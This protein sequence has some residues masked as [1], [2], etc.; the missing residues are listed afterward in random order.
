MYLGKPFLVFFPLTLVVLVVK[1]PFA[2]AGDRKRCSFHFWVKK[3]PFRRKCNP[4]VFLPGKSHRQ[5]DLAGYR[6]W[7]SQKVEYD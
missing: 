3:I 4:P 5:R 2:N 7:G 1:N 6:P